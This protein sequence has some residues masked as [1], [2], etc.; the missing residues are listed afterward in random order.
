MKQGQAS[1]RIFALKTDPV[2]AGRTSSLNDLGLRLA[3][4]LLVAAAFLPASVTS[5]RAQSSE[6]RESYGGPESIG[7]QGQGESQSSV[8]QATVAPV[9]ALKDRLAR[10]YGLEISADYN[11][12]FQYATESLGEDTA[13][14]GAARLYGR[15]SPR[16]GAFGSLVFK[17]EHRHLL[18]T[19]ISPQELGPE[20]GYLGLTTVPF[21]DKGAVLN[22]LY[23]TKSI[24]DNRFAF[25]VGVVDVTDYV[26]VYML[27]NVWSEFNN[28]VFGTNPTIP[29]PDNGLGAVARWNVT[30]NYYVVAGIADANGDPRKPD[31]FLHNFF[32]VAE[33]F[34]HVEVG[35]ISS[36]ENRFT[37]NVHVTFW[38]A[39]RRDAAMVPSG[40]GVAASWMQRFG[41]RW[42]PF[43]RAGYSDGGGAI[44]DRSV[45][46]GVGYQLNERND[47]IGVGASW[48]RPPKDFTNG[49]AEDQYA[50][51]AYY[52]INPLPNLEI[53]PS[54]QFIVNPALNPTAESFWVPSLRVRTKL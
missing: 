44:L 41:E 11:A 13:A 12:L 18:G 22:H 45:I 24:A 27:A 36:W 21:K 38:Q 50:F 4:A 2:K 28:M 16:N 8:E 17:V 23:W 52:R 47:F 7:A 40:W 25:N 26:D 19:D 1:E 43:V 46:T 14:G 9:S 34:R 51:E 42:F 20:A 33:Y 35:W 49:K 32:E 48:G 53:T 15:W 29:A 39:D 6:H 31:E 5:P 54:I 30:P 10:V 3:A 37:D